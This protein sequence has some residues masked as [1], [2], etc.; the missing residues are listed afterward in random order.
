MGW[1]SSHGVFGCLAAGD[2]EIREVEL[3]GDGH[4][5]RCDPGP[6][7]AFSDPQTEL[8]ENAGVVFRHIDKH[9]VGIEEPL[10]MVE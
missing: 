8:E 9:K 7:L 1:T 6:R 4:L 5:D 10:T 2:R 3:A